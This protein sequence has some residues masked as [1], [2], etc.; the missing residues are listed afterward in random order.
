MKIEMN[1]PTPEVLFV[2][3]TGDMDS[4]SAESFYEDGLKSLDASARWLVIDCSRVTLIS[5]KGVGVIIRLGAV[6][7][8]RG[9]GAFLVAPTQPIR[10]VLSLMGLDALIPTCETV[11]EAMARTTA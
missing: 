3:I 1:R 2:Q 10:T 9:G 7:G 4:Y 6:C 5:S 8:S 11:D